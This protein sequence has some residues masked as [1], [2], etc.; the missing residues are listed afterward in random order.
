MR[1]LVLFAV[2]ALLLCAET[3]KPRIAVGG[4]SHETDTFNP[5]KTGLA[6]FGWK[7]G[8][9][10]DDFLQDHEMASTTISGYLE[11]A[12]RFG[13]QLYPTLLARATPKGRGRD[14]SR[15]APP[16]QIRT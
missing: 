10:D 6:D 3:G 5:R 7:E 15:P 1:L 9:P 8:G 13:L 11:A 2:P 14:A 12:Q 4:I 16:A